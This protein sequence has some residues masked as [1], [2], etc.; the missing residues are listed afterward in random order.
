MSKPRRRQQEIESAFDPDRAGAGDRPFGEGVRYRSGVHGRRNHGGRDVLQCHLAAGADC[1]LGCANAPEDHALIPSVSA[2]PARKN[3]PCA[4]AQKSAAAPVIRLITRELRRCALSKMGCLMGEYGRFFK[5]VQR[6]HVNAIRTC[7]YRCNM[8]LEEGSV[9]AQPAGS[10]RTR[11]STTPVPASSRQTSNS[12]K[13]R[14]RI[15]LLHPRT[16]EHLLFRSLPDILRPSSTPN[17]VGA[18][19]E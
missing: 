13:Y 15:P 6:F 7:C 2:L 12:L 19:L 1:R 14:T 8:P 3:S 11:Q 5:G 4:R 17:P 9:V 18:A 16:S 10:R